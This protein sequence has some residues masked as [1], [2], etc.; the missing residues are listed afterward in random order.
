MCHIP[1]DRKIINELLVTKVHISVIHLA[2]DHWIENFHFI[3]KCKQMHS[4][5]AFQSNKVLLAKQP[6]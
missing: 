5:L 3:V 2:F 6:D 1:I 4:F